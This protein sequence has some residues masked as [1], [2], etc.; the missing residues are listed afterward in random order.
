MQDNISFDCTP[1]QKQRYND[2]QAFQ[3]SIIT[4]E[5]STGQIK[6]VMRIQDN[7]DDNNDENSER[8]GS[9]FASGGESENPESSP[10]EIL[11]GIMIGAI[12]TFITLKVREWYRTHK[13]KRYQKSLIEAINEYNSAAVSGK[14][15][16]ETINNLDEELKIYKSR[17]ECGKIKEDQLHHALIENC[18]I[19]VKKA[20]R[21]MEADLQDTSDDSSNDNNI[22]DIIDILDYQ[23]NTLKPA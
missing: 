14:L 18:Y 11:A 12:C 1:E 19:S 15:T 9:A 6:D 16:L 13:T 8:Y 2:T 7:E 21:Y 17:A 22:S 5:R 20:L 3:R 10:V 4:R 23:R